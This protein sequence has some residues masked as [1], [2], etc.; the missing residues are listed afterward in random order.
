[1][2]SI[3]VQRLAVFPAFF[4]LGEGADIDPVIHRHFGLIALGVRLIFVGFHVDG[5]VVLAVRALHRRGIQGA[6]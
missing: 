3:P 5:D 4:R 6:I 2:H 1:M